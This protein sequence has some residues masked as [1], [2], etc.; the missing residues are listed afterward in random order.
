VG[1]FWIAIKDQL[2]VTSGETLLTTMLGGVMPQ[3]VILT[4]TFPLIERAS[5]PP[6]PVKERALVL[7]LIDFVTPCIVK[8]A[9]TV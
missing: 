9:V 6:S 1:Y 4:F 5:F 8:S 7:K 2:I 3:L